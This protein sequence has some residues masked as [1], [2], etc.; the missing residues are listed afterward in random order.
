MDMFTEACIM[1]WLSD[2]R[3][4]NGMIF[5]LQGFGRGVFGGNY[6]T[7]NMLHM[8]PGLDVVC[9]SNGRD[10]SRGMRYALQQCRAGRVS[11]FVDC[12]E[13]LNM[14]EVEKGVSWEMAYTERD[15]FVSYDQVFTYPSPSAESTTTLIVTYGSGVPVA[16]Q[17]QRLLAADAGIAVDVVDCPLL[18]TCP[19]GLEDL[20][21]AKHYRRIIFADICKEGQNPLA[22]HMS[23]LLNENIIEQGAGTRSSVVRCVTAQRTYNPLGTIL[24]FLSRDDMI[25][26]VKKVQQQ[27]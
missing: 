5:R 22:S 11:M 7:H 9:Y 20:L 6:H 2:G 4:R 1:N 10:Y 16:L 13:L 12:T 3:Q 23:H 18:S 8:P 26:A 15:E 24:T 21:R 17:A 27:A 25:D 19:K 14:R